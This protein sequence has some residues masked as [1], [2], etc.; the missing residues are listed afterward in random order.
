MKL[1]YITGAVLILASCNNPAVDQ[2]GETTKQVDSAAIV[3]GNDSSLLTQEEIQTPDS[4]SQDTIAH[5]S[6][7]VSNNPDL[8]R[9]LV[10]DDLVV[11]AN[12]N[13]QPSTRHKTI[14][15]KTFEQH[16]DTL[17]K[18]AIDAYKASEHLF[19]VSIADNF[20]KGTSVERIHYPETLT[21]RFKLFEKESSLKPYQ[22]V[23]VTVRRK[24]NGELYTE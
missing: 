7:G 9:K 17:S 21:F 16:P 18:L 11:D 23:D 6:A 5:T 20:E 1:Y 3:G 10:S 13:G 12:L 15:K 4:A 22:I 14:P 24:L 19:P 2:T 8:T